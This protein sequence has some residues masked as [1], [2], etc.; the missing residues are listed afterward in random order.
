MYT[1]KKSKLYLMGGAYTN[2]R[3][4]S[5]PREE[6]MASTQ[7]SG[8]S[9]LRVYL[10]DSSGSDDD[11]DSSTT[12]TSMVQLGN[13]DGGQA[14]NSLHVK[15]CLIGDACVGKT[16][17]AMQV[18]YKQFDEHLAPT[19]GIDV[20]MYDRFRVDRDRPL[21]TLQL[22]DTSGQ[23]RFNALVP[24]YLRSAWV[25]LVFYDVN[26]RD[27]FN[28]VDKWVKLVREARGDNVV[29]VIIGNKIDLTGARQ[30]SDAEG[31]QK[32]ADLDCH[33][34]PCTNKLHPH[35]MRIMRAAVR[36]VPWPL[37]SDWVLVPAD[38]QDTGQT[39]LIGN[40]KSTGGPCSC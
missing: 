10:T 26:R 19:L 8:M 40:E 32:A 25:A 37:P 27:T 3:R 18:R 16:S 9:A 28:S 36:L 34:F 13:D 4:G 22:W 6:K 33:Y 38:G 20:V 21:I 29:V 14:D 39:V 5:S 12:A 24:S 17:F 31:E 11:Y 15:A 23:E 7:S 1:Q 2:C 35:T 30:V